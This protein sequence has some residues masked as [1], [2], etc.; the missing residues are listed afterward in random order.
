MPT[1][2]DDVGI[3]VNIGS[4]TRDA[5]YEAHSPT[6]RRVT[7]IDWDRLVKLQTEHYGK[8]A[9]GARR[10]PPVAPVCFLTAEG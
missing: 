5:T 8:L 2:A 3:F 7:L 1:A 10:R 4:F 6:T 9:K